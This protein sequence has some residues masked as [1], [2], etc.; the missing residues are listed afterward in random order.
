MIPNSLSRSLVDPFAVEPEGACG[1]LMEAL[2]GAAS[3]QPITYPATGGATV[4]VQTSTAGSDKGVDT[5][6]RLTTTMPPGLG[7]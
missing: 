2:D 1:D 3:H 6:Q 7:R 4:Y 5:L